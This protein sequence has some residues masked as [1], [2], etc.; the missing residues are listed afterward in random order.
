MQRQFL[1]DRMCCTGLPIYQYAAQGLQICSAQNLQ[2]CSPHNQIN[3]ECD[4]ERLHIGSAQGLQICFAPCLK[5]CCVHNPQM[6]IQMLHMVCKHNICAAQGLQIYCIYACIYAALG[7]RLYFTGPQTCC[8]KAANMYCEKLA[9]MLH[10]ACQDMLRGACKYE[11]QVCK[12]DTH[13][14]KKGLD[15]DQTRIRHGLDTIRHG[16]DTIRHD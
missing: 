5:M 16:L 14:G 7:L 9:D 12:Y 10:R 11:A 8:T 1:L 15:T 6:P 4:A 2:I 13:A 3:Q